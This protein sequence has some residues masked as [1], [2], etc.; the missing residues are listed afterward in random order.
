M[1]NAASTARYRAAEAALWQA[2]GRVPLERW[3]RVPGFG[4]RV[5]V[6]EIGEG[7]PVLLVHGGPNAGSTW[8]SLA[9][10]LQGHRCLVLDRPGCGLSE[11][12]PF[13]DPARIMPAMVEVQVAVLDALGATRVSLVGSS[14]GGACVLAL[15]AARPE[16]IDR[17]VIEGVPALMGVRLAPNM[18]PLAIGPV[19]WAIARLPASRGVITRTFRQLGHGE[20]VAKGWP[21]GVDLA[22]ALSMVNDTDTMRHDVDLI[23]HV[24]TWRG[25]HDLLDPSVLARITAPTLWLWGG[26][27]PFATVDQGRR[28]AATMPAADFEVFERSGH[29]PWYDDPADHAERIGAFLATPRPAPRTAVLTSA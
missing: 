20:L 29:L 12:I 13:R 22:W 19:G 6:L 17:I 15:A 26:L 24:A 7:P 5:R 9:G 27:D 3:V 16:R 21:A 11:R 28:W 10:R 2:G 25:F 23:Q 4:I 8:A 1:V 18:L 14:F